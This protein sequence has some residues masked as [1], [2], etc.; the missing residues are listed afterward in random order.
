MQLHA[1]QQEPLL[2]L[3]GLHL[4]ELVEGDVEVV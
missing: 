4:L 1:I 3:F 2:L